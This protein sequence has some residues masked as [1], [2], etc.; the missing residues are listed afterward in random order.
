MIRLPPLPFAIR[1][2]RDAVLVMICIAAGGA[3]GAAPFTQGGADVRMVQIFQAVFGTL[4]F[5]FAGFHARSRRALH[6]LLTTL[7]IGL[8]A[9]LMV[10]LGGRHAI[11]WLFTLTALALMALLG[12]GLARLFER[13]ARD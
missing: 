12:G 2:L 7:V 3:L 1:V 4:G 8:F 9:G 5:A 6:L 10:A 11:W 13:L